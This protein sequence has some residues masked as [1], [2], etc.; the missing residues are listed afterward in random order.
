MPEKQPPP[1]QAVSITENNKRMR[2]IAYACR[3]A[4]V[5]QSV[6]T[7]VVGVVL[8]RVYAWKDLD[9]ALHI[10]FLSLG[11][12]VFGWLVYLLILSALTIYS[13]FCS[14]FLFRAAFVF[15]SPDKIM[16]RAWWI[17]AIYGIVPLG[18]LLGIYISCNQKKWLYEIS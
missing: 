16:F 13:L 12:V 15:S 2:R 14:I 6:F 10:A 5:A 17:Q 4:A 3:I 7:L 9:Y 1:L 8:S 18:T 11:I